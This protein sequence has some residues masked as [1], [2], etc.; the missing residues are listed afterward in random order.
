MRFLILFLIPLTLAAQ[1]GANKPV[2]QKTESSIIHDSLVELKSLKPE[3]FDKKIDDYRNAIEKYIETK[4]RVCNGE[5]TTIILSDSAAKPDQEA[6]KLT[7]EEKQLCFN[8]LKAIYKTYINHL[9]LVRT[10]FIEF[11]NEKRIKELAVIRDA[12]LKSID[13]TFNRKR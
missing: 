7:K 11:L 3:E 5:F 4:K 6:K 13:S 8:E 2:I 12:T 1:S 9:F 10:R